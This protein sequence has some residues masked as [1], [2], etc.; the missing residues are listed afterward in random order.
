VL[1]R[2]Q[3]RIARDFFRRYTAAEPAD[4][5]GWI[6][7]G[8]A[9]ATIGNLSGAMSSYD[10]AERLAPAERDVQIGRARILANAGH[11]DDAIAAYARWTATHPDDAEALRN[12]GDQQRRAGRYG[13]ARDSY[14]A[15]QRLA[16]SQQTAAR[17][18]LVRAKSAPWIR[19]E[20]AGSHDSDENDTKEAGASIGAALGDRLNV[21]TSGSR[22]WVTGIPDFSFPDFTIDK[23]T[24]GFESRPLASLRLDAS[25]GAA[26]SQAEGADKRTSFAIG[27]A[28]A[29]WRQPGGRGSLDVRATRVLLDVSPMLVGNQVVRTEI[30]GRGDLPLMSRVSL[31][32]GA[33]AAS[34]NSIDDD[35]T[36]LSLLGGLAVGVTPTIEVSTVFQRI[37]YD[38]ASFVGYFAP[39]LAELAEV[40]S[41]SEFESDG[42]VVLELDAGAGMA[43]YTEF[44]LTA[45]DWKPSYRL[46]AAVDA[47]LSAANNLRVEL[48]TYDSRLGGAA[49]TSESWRFFSLTAALRVAF[50]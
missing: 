24:V 43:R 45:G 18:D 7:L 47:P 38:K 28:R 40:G 17:I 9:Y 15:A 11:T 16:P 29:A 13:E 19:A 46:L 20:A 36:R 33:K 22:R 49:A 3:P 39:K 2:S 32:A 12:L 4:A 44:G 8:D 5:W 31:R 25:G 27:S 1:N 42:G 35:N 37:T 10:V 14:A 30:G 50:R 48:D 6:A 21:R 26:F 23:V 41:Y 34:F